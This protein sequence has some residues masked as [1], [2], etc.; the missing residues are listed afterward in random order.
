MLFRVKN[1]KIQMRELYKK[2]LD[3]PKSESIGI[4]Y[5]NNISSIYISNYFY[6]KNIDFFTKENKFDFYS[7]N[8]LTDIKNILIFSNDTTN[9]ETFKKIYFKFNSYIK[10]EFI[11]KL[12]YKSFNACVLDTLLDL[13]E[14]NN[15][16]IKKF[17]DL[18]NNF[19][20]LKKINMNKK[21]DFILNELGYE[22]YLDNYNEFSNTNYNLIVDTLKYIS[23]DIKT[24]DE[25]I[26]RIENIKETLKNATKSISNISIS[27]IHSSK[28]LEYDNVFILDLVDGEFPQKN[29][30]NSFDKNI[31]EEE[32][33]LFYVAITRAKKNLFLFTLKERN[34]Y[35]V[36]TSRFYNELKN[37]K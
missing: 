27:T 33:R 3:I 34:D 18:R 30:I 26:E 32:R 35:P 5:R 31:L 17:N 19:K 16:Y 9:L 6:I 20:K 1:S 8:I 28:G 29:I 15:F 36:I 7:N 14:I 10:K 13:D 25:F 11:N 37:L 23:E 21:I 12:E 24:F 2:I 4:L 22:E